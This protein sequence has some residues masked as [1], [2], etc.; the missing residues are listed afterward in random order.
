[1]IL[2]PWVSSRFCFFLFL[3]FDALTSA[4]SLATLLSLRANAVI[5]LEDDLVTRSRFNVMA[6]ALA[7]PRA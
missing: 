5:L 4:H 3:Q 2:A 6:W 1:M 7:G